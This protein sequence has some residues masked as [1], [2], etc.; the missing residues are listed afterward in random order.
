MRAIRAI[1]F[2][3]SPL[4][5]ALA[6]ASA[7]S[8]DDWD[9]CTRATD[10][11]PAPSGC[12]ADTCTND[13]SSGCKCIRAC[14]PGWSG[15]VPNYVLAQNLTATGDCL[16]PSVDGIR[17]YGDP[18]YSIAAGGAAVQISNRSGVSVR[19]LTADGDVRMTGDGAD[20][21]FIG[22]VT[23]FGEIR[24]DA[25]DSNTVVS[26]RMAGFAHNVDET[27]PALCT[28]FE[29]NTVESDTRIDL[30][31]FLGMYSS[32]SAPPPIYCPVTKF[33][34][35]D[36]TMISRT[37][38]TSDGPNVLRIR[39]AKD[40]RILNNTLRAT[41]TAYGIYLRDQANDSLFQDNTVWTDRGPALHLSS[42]NDNKCCSAGNRFVHNLFRSDRADAFYL[43]GVG[44]RNVFED[45]L[46][47]SNGGDG[48]WVQ[49]PRGAFF[50]HNTFHNAASDGHLF[51]WPYGGT[52]VAPD[53]YTNNVFSFAW[54]SS[55]S[56]IIFDGV[57]SWNY[58]KYEGDRNLFHNRSGDALFWKAESL[59]DWVRHSADAGSPDDAHSL[60]GDPAFRNP[61]ACDFRIGA[62][63]STPG[64][65][66]ADDGTDVG[67]TWAGVSRD[68]GCF[69]PTSPEL[70]LPPDP[71]PP[72]GP[73][74][75][76]PDGDPPPSGAPAPAGPGGP[77]VDGMFGGSCGET[78]GSSA[79][80]IV[81]LPALLILISRRKL[82]G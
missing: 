57:P 9:T 53:L 79:F 22:N 50:N 77:S 30:V 70:S 78:P 46:L 28:T 52:G 62:D 27:Q 72:G 6:G 3:L 16:V 59:A 48:F 41:G 18:R 67:I 66:A 17:I 19:D 20:R 71:A 21:N 69:V 13:G 75:T 81:A 36:N 49:G 65:R 61:A 68:G 23:V 26:S 32:S 11:G 10:P 44:D 25:G 5:F 4:L 37:T 8:A 64:H 7:F 14:N 76:P 80:A 47:W 1:G 24:I 29:R 40:N 2:T 31:E 55:S 43:Q 74:I 38:A 58:S 82:P 34:I 42:G 45:N 56:M 54:S 39:C 12:S 33:L 60:E 63:A 51:R 73:G 15:S 35:R